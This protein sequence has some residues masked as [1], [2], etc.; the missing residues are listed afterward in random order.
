MAIFDGN[1]LTSEELKEVIGGY[2]YTPDAG[3]YFVIN[4]KTGDPMGEFTLLK[5]KAIAQAEYYG[6]STE[7]I[8]YDQ[9]F[10]LK[11]GKK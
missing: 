7:M 2:I 3:G 10:E 1:K 11:H 4:D 6:Q 9:L 5:G 8:T